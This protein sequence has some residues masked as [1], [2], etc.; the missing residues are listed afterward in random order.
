[1]F[2]FGG[3]GTRIQVLFFINEL[4]SSSIDL[5]HSSFIVEFIACLYEVG[6]ETSIMAFAYLGFDVLV[7]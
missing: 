5:I 4:I 1:M 6:S 3:V 7:L 2:V